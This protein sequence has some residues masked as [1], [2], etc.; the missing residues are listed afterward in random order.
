METWVYIAI[1]GGG[2]VIVVLLFLLLTR[3]RGGARKAVPA[4]G[5]AATPSSGMPPNATMFAG[6]GMP[7]SI[8]PAS[9]RPA[10]PDEKT[11]QQGVVQ[12]CGS[13]GQPMSP[14]WTNCA[15][16]GWAPPAAAAQLEVKSGPM[17]GAFVGLVGEVTTVGSMDGN[18]LVLREANVGRKALGIR[19]ASGVYELADLGNPG[20]ILVNGQRMAKRNLSPGDIVR[21]G[22]SE[23]VFRTKSP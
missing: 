6:A 21:V 18:A 4:Q 13:C 12:M 22:T 1:A 9:A 2:L 17:A 19:R 7:Q 11:Q 8:P 15:A 14:E 20:G 16:C 23:L 5:P 10:R 3:G